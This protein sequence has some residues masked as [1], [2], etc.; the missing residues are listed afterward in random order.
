MEHFRP[1][2]NV[3]TAADRG[4]EGTENGQ[5]LAVASGEFDVVV[6]RDTSL[7]HQKNLTR[8]DLALIVLR[9]RTDLL[10]DL[11]QLM[12]DVNRI[13]PDLGP[14][15]VVEVHPDVVRRL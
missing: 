9:G 10:H 12:P 6:T 4:L 3:T 7:R 5:L 1:P 14:G 8:Y 15:A 11:V 13:L 2:V